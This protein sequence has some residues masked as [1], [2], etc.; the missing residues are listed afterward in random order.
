MAAHLATILNFGN[1]DYSFF[2]N[3][4]LKPTQLLEH[5]TNQINATGRRN[6]TSYPGLT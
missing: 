3:Y 2:D 4:V 1:I 5:E 6:S